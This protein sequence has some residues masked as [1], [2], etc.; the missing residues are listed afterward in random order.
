MNAIETA[1]VVGG[2]AVAA[3][4]LGATGLVPRARRRAGR[5]IGRAVTRGLSKPPT[6]PARWAAEAVSYTVTGVVLLCRFLTDPVR[7]TR[8]VREVQAVRQAARSP[9]VRAAVARAAAVHSDRPVRTMHIRYHHPGA[10]PDLQN[11]ALVHSR[12]G[13]DVTYVTLGGNAPGWGE[14]IDD[15]RRAQLVAARESLEQAL[16]TVPV[17]PNIHGIAVKVVA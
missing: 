17:G 9:E 12:D 7:T 3:Y 5:S 4:H 2:T 11:V 6:H 13:R 16:R 10:R 15:V 8:F 14:P 1:V